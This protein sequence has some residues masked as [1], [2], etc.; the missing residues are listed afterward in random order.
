MTPQE[1]FSSPAEE[2]WIHGSDI[3]V[4]ESG[5]LWVRAEADLWPKPDRETYRP[6]RTASSMEARE[7][8]ILTS[9]RITSL[10]VR[11]RTEPVWGHICE[12]ER[13]S[14]ETGWIAVR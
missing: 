4:D 14:L 7:Y 13:S 12:R 6:D 9:G 2:Q 10:N 8:S 11:D 1:L 5:G 3:A